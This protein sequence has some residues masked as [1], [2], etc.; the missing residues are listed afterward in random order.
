MTTL[1]DSIGN[2]TNL[3]ELHVGDNQLTTLPDSIIN[4]TNLETLDV[5]ENTREDP[6]VLTIRRSLLNSM[7]NNGVD[8]IMDNNITIIEGAQANVP[9]ASIST[10][11]TSVPAPIQSSPSTPTPPQPSLNKFKQ[12]VLEINQYVESFSKKIMNKGPTILA[13]CSE[14]KPLHNK[15]I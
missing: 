14:T 12:N 7:E 6:T 9:E 1:P 15:E 4:L 2:L 8:V 10:S 3:Q 11:S 13:A 5:R